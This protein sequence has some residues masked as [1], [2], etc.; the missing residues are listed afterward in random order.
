MTWHDENFLNKEY[1]YS[2]FY[3]DI[4]LFTVRRKVIDDA[5]YF[6]PFLTLNCKCTQTITDIY[7]SH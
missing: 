1:I 7:F 5:K 2:K 3:A 4:F 6:K